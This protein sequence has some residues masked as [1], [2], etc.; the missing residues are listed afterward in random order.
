[1]E[2]LKKVAKPISEYLLLGDILFLSM[3]TEMETMKRILENI[4]MERYEKENE[5]CARN[6]VRNG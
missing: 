6:L 2:I 3:N 4:S 5:Q 1:M